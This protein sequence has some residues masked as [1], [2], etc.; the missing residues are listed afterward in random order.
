MDI[1]QML[2]RLLED[3]EKRDAVLLEA[4]EQRD[5]E[6]AEERRLREE[7]RRTRELEMREE[8]RLR[9]EEMA[10][11]EDKSR[12]QMAIL[13]SLVE[14]VQKQGEAAALKI[15]KEK[16]IRVAELTE[17]AD[18][19]AYLTTFE[20][21]MIA[22][23]VQ[24]QRRA[25]NLAPQLTEK[26]QQAHAGMPNVDAGSYDKLKA[27]ILLRYDV[28]EERYRQQFRAAKRKEGETNHELLHGS[29]T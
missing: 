8:R 3:R 24:R 15:E 26:A 7:E 6:L 14:G 5:A 27:A 21:Q 28:T 12:Q 19:E 16:D 2:K 10:R 9:E 23:E 17:S 13:R 22:Y 20:R 1:T 4:R 29:K 25:F 18:I 11:R